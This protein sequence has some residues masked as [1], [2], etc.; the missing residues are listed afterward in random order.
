MNG[1]KKEENCVQQNDCL[2]ERLQNSRGLANTAEQ[3][4]MRL[5]GALYTAQ[6]K[7]S[8]TARDVWNMADALA[9]LNENL[10][11]LCDRLEK[12]CDRVGC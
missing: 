4:V 6:E 3:M 1:T 9:D 10:M 12:L 5:A 7:P 2:I 8:D 11:G